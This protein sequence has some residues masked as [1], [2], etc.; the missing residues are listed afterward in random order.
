M[1]HTT[2]RDVPD[3][4]TR[5]PPPTPRDPIWKSVRGAY[6]PSS[7]ASPVPLPPVKMEPDSPLPASNCT[8]VSFLE[9]DDSMDYVTNDATAFTCRGI[10]LRKKFDPAN[11]VGPY[12]PAL[13]KAME[14]VGV[15]IGDLVVHPSI[16]M[17]ETDLA[18]LRSIANRTAPLRPRSTLGAMYGL[19]FTCESDA[20]SDE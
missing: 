10:P 8:P 11:L 16:P 6:S 1:T 2:V 19:V 4:A 5:K 20:R 15:A 3:E 7:L 9:S 17:P 14:I 18:L 12:T 13:Q